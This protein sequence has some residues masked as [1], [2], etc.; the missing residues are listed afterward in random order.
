MVKS[1]N[2]KLKPNMLN[3]FKK[4]KK[5]NLNSPEEFKLKLPE[6]HIRYTYEWMDDVP[7]ND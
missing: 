6:I 5:N 3:F 1:Q 7:E 2:D 4:K